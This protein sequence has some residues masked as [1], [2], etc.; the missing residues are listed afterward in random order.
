MFANKTGNLTFF[1]QN[2]FVNLCDYIHAKTDIWQHSKN[3]GVLQY[4]LWR[5]Q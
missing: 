5:K 3:Y 2:R 1:S 4:I